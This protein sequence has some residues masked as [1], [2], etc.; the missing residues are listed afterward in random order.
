MF[1]CAQLKKKK[2]SFTLEQIMV[3]WSH[4]FGLGVLFWGL[5][6]IYNVSS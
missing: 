3:E 6:S 4:L 1:C 5:E 2:N